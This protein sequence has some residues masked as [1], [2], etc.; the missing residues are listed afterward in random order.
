MAV[1]ISV[2]LSNSAKLGK[3]DPVLQPAEPVG[4]A[5]QENGEIDEF[6]SAI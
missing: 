5:V 4:K 2:R 3:P 6:E 1:L